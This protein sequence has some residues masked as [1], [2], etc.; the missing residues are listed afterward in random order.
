MQ[1]RVPI[2]QKRK[3]LSP[4]CEKAAIYKSGKKPL[5]ESSHAGML[6]LNSQPPEL[7]GNRS[8]LHERRKRSWASWYIPIIP[9][10]RK[11]RQEDLVQGQP[12]LHS[13]SREKKMR[14]EKWK[15]DKATG[16]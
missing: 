3:K 10:L 13:S 16:K 14:K 11:P 4:P 15:E 12:G 6:I 1:K 5:P 2:S 9:A 7:G 8:L